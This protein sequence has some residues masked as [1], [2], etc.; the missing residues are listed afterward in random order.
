MVNRVKKTRYEE[1]TKPTVCILPEDMH[2]D[3]F[4][5]VAVHSI[6]HAT[7]VVANTDHAQAEITQAALQIPVHAGVWGLMTPKPP[8]KVNWVEFGYNIRITLLFQFYL[9]EK[10]YIDSSST[11]Y[12]ALHDFFHMSDFFLHLVRT[13]RA[14]GHTHTHRETHRLLQ[15]WWHRTWHER[16]QSILIFMRMKYEWALLAWVQWQSY[17]FK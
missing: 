13:R 2:S 16:L 14:K 9:L 8:I 15:R 7:V 11:F 10:C 4:N 3:K 1:Y 5:A 6:S 17:T 12:K